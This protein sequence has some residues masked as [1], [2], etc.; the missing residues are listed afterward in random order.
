MK[1]LI[2]IAMIQPIDGLNVCFVLI[3]HGADQSTV[4]NNL[5]MKGTWK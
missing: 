3:M 2:F 4:Y 5:R 1:S